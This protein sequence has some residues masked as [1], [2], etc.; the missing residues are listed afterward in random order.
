MSKYKR[1]DEIQT[2]E[3]ARRVGQ[4]YGREVRETTL[5][6]AVQITYMNGSRELV[7]VYT[8]YEIEE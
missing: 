5:V 1:A 2:G 7:P 3:R 8:E 6:P 4:P